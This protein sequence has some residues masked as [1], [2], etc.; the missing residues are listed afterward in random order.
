LDPIN[1]RRDLPV[2]RLDPAKMCVW[3]APRLSGGAVAAV[4]G[5]CAALTGLSSV[6]SAPRAAVKRR[7]GRV[8]ERR[9]RARGDR[10]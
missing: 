8:E 3:A 4:E 5:S 6:R 9:E 1:V 2:G 7:Q 10:A